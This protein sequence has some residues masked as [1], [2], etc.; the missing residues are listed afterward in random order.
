MPTLYIHA[1]FH[2]T[3]TSTIQKFF[4]K[5]NKAVLEAINLY[6]P[7]AGTE[8][9]K[10]E[11]TSTGTHK[12]LFPVAKY[13]EQ[14]KKLRDEID[15]YP[16]ADILISDEFISY[17]PVPENYKEKYKNRNFREFISKESVSYINKLLPNY[18]IKIILCLRRIDHLFK[19]FYGQALKHA[20]VNDYKSF[21]SLFKN[22]KSYML[23][24]SKLIQYF[25]DIIGKENTILFLYDK[26]EMSHRF[27][28]SMG[29][30]LPETLS[31]MLK[32]QKTNKSFPPETWP[33]LTSTLISYTFPDEMRKDL[34]SDV[35]KFFLY[36]NSGDDIGEVDYGEFQKEIKKVETY[37]PGYE[38]LYKN[39]PISFSFPQINAE[40]IDILLVGLLYRQ[41]A[42]LFSLKTVLLNKIE[43]IELLVQKVAETTH[44]VKD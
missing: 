41:Q 38:E 36:P 13:K 9:K 4:W 2:K 22:S 16:D 15:N 6:Y 44:V 32:N 31:K 39:S 23:F 42:E 24:P 29:R 17:Y 12:I 14:W 34:I 40:Y 19:S 20:A 33:F 10:P 37:C 8:V 27:L 25:H 21:F 28:E 11:G 3:G 26:N 7:R 18:N 30:K 5:H 35:Q 1:G 43:R